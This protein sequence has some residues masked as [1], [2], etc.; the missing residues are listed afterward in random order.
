M[1]TFHYNDLRAADHKDGLKQNVWLPFPRFQLTDQERIMASLSL[2][3]WV[4]SKAGVESVFGS[5]NFWLC[6]RKGIWPV[7]NYRKTATII[8][9][10]NPAQLGLTAKRRPIK[11]KVNVSSSSK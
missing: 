11:Q 10:E 2:F 3:E 6:Y 7:K 1:T 9:I 5:L 8:P 4:I